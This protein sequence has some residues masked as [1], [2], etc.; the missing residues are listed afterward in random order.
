MR[1]LDCFIEIIA[2]TSD[3]IQTAAE[4]QPPFEQVKNAYTVLFRRSE[5]L[6]NKGQYP[7]E[8]RDSA[9]FAVCAWVDESIIC[10]SW[11]GK[12]LWLHE[13]LQR[14][15]YKSTNAGEAFFDRLR[16]LDPDAREVREVFACCLALGFKGRYF[17]W[18]DELQLENIRSANMQ[19]VLN[20][21][22]LEQSKKDNTNLFPGAYKVPSEGDTGH[23]LKSPFSLFTLTFLLWP[24][25][26]FGVLYF[27]YQDI[28]R[29]LIAGFFGT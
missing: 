27:L 3:F 17:R 20:E 10:S 21:R 4:K 22:L 5:N 28:L 18:E 8:D 6:M 13:Q 19:Y 16:E 9:R 25:V 12:S 11:E 2:Y 1:L 24:P 7:P 15:F 14:V 29:R 26:L 23:K